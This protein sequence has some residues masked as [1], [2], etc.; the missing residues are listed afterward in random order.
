MSKFIGAI[1][2]WITFSAINPFLGLFGAFI[3]LL[4]GHFFGAGFVSIQR[5]ARQYSPEEK[6]RMEA[7]FL[8]ALF[9]IMGHIAK[10]DGRIC[11]QEI[12]ATEQL[13]SKIGLDVEARKIAI[14]QFNVGASEE[15]DLDGLLQQFVAAA[16]DN[17]NLKH[18]FL[19]YLISLAF[20]DGHL[21]ETEDAILSNIAK[22]LGYTR[23]SYLRMLGMIEAQRQFYRGQYQESGYHSNDNRSRY[24]SS[25]RDELKLA[26]EALGVEKTASDKEVKM[27]W[28]RLMSEYHPD[29]LSGRGVPEDMIKLATERSQEIQLAYDLIKK[30]RK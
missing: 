9:P 10:A 6:K 18:I 29:K 21:H 26:Y 8:Q 5:G 28:R 7:A 3:G 15:F 12:K 11:E 1:I 27:A 25:D 23:F 24:Q 2:G 14:Q 13:F 30:S 4:V 17:A 22:K 16:E 20:A 19:A